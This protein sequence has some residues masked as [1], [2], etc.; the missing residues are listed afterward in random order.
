M[1]N[2]DVVQV[3]GQPNYVA[4]FGIAFAKQAWISG[5]ILNPIPSTRCVRKVSCLEEWASGRLVQGMCCW[6]LTL[7]TLLS[8]SYIVFAVERRVRQVDSVGFPW[9][10]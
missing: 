6:T 3:D 4:R 9:K 1:C 2:N 8:W 7:S 10:L 5:R